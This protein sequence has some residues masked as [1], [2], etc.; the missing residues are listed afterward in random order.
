MVDVKDFRY[1]KVDGETDTKL[2]MFQIKENGEILEEKTKVITHAFPV[3]GEF[4]NE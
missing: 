4:D 3:K 2:F 1:Y